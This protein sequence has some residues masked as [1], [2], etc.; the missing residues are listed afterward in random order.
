MQIQ[1]TC[2]VYNAKL[3]HILQYPITYYFPLKNQY[4]KG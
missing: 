4:R 1:T 3:K 2:L